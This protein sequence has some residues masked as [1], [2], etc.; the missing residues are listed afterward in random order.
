MKIYESIKENSQSL[1]LMDISTGPLGV[2][3]TYT[4]NKTSLIHYHIQLTDIEAHKLT[5][6]LNDYF[7]DRFREDEN[8][9]ET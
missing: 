5:E 2:E 6:W 4:P 9:E 8:K 1:E 7:Y 3:I